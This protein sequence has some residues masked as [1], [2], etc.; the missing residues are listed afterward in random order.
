MLAN[1]F[2]FWYR[3]GCSSRQGAE[4]AGKEVE[5]CCCLIRHR[6][7][8]RR[9]RWTTGSSSGRD[10]LHQT[11]GS[12]PFWTLCLQENRQEVSREGLHDRSHDNRIKPAT[13]WSYTTSC[14]LKRSRDLGFK[15]DFSHHPGCLCTDPAPGRA[16]WKWAEDL[17]YSSVTTPRWS[18]A[19][20]PRIE[21]TSAVLRTNSP[22]S[23]KERKT[24]CGAVMRLSV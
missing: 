7:P 2:F 4:P 24:Q 17:R 14:F 19:T 8:F 11:W 23:G 22:W 6:H 18:Y 1:F 16:A 12:G 13:Q 3:P 21:R 5:G 10:R 20:P 15:R 9:G